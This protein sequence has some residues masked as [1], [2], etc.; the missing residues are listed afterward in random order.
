MSVVPA[1]WRRS[2]N[3][4]EP[5]HP[6]FGMPPPGCALSYGTISKT[7]STTQPS[8]QGIS[9]EE[10]FGFDQ[11]GRRWGFDLMANKIRTVMPRDP[12]RHGT[13]NVSSLGRRQRGRNLELDLP[14]R[15]GA[16]SREMKSAVGDGVGVMSSPVLSNMMIIKDRY[17]FKLK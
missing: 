9:L 11:L 5:W 17:L 14:N 10:P 4:G 12:A 3:S 15:S 16:G 6:P 2:V 1:L 13:V 7:L 8:C